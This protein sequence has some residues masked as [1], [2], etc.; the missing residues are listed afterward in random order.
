VAMVSGTYVLTDTISK[1]FDEIFSG[2]YRSTSAV[3]VGKQI[4][5]YSSSGNATVPASVLERVKRLPDVEAASGQVF[6]L[7]SSA[8]YGKLIDRDGKALGSGGAP[9][10]AFGL[11]GS[12]PRFNPL[13]LAAGRWAQGSDEVV[14]DQSSAKKAHFG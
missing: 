3:I 2:S 10:F 8:D 12:Q 14:I 6:D 5:D 11:D 13:T 1:A 4:V 9:T 7:S